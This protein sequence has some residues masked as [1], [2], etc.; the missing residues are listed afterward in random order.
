MPAETPPK[1]LASPR[2]MRERMLAGEPYGVDRDLADRTDRAADLAA[3]YGATPASAR[4]TRQAV[5][6]D[7]LGT[8]GAGCELAGTGAGRLTTG[9]YVGRAGNGPASQRRGP[10]LAAVQAGQRRVSR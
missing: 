9:A 6:G 2:T 4:D 8:V 10:A 5:L 1:T 7:L 3:T